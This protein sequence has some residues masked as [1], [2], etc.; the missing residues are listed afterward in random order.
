MKISAEWAKCMQTTPA[1]TET[2]INPEAY[3]LYCNDITGGDL[4][5]N[6]GYTEYS[7][8][9]SG[10]IIYGDKIILNEVNKDKKN[11]SLINRLDDIDYIADIADIPVYKFWTPG[12][13]SIGSFV[14]LDTET[15]AIPDGDRV[16]IPTLVLATA[17][18][19]T[20]SYI[21]APDQVPAFLTIHKDAT[22]ILHNAP[23]DR[24]V[25]LQACNTDLCDWLDKGLLRDTG[26]LY[27][28]LILAEEGLVP[29]RWSLDLLAEK[30]L[31]ID[32]PK[33][34]SIRL[35]F[36]QYLKPDGAVDIAGISEE[37]LDYAVKD[38]AVTFMLYTALLTRIDSVCDLHGVQPSLLLGHNIHL[39][40]AIALDVV[41]RNGMC[42][43]SVQVEMLKSNFKVEAEK[44]L[45]EL[46]GKFGFA[47]GTGSAAKYQSIMSDIE[48]SSGITF[49]RT[50]TGKIS[51]AEDDLEAYRE[52]EFINLFLAY[53]GIEKIVST[54]I[55]KL[56]GRQS[57]HPKF[58][59]LV[60]TGR[61]SCASPNIQQLPREGG[62]RDAFISSD[63]HC[64]LTAD[65]SAIELCGLAQI[66]YEKYGSSNMR[67]LINAGKDLH[68]ELAAK[69]TGKNPADITKE[70]RSKAKAAG[71]GFPGGLG[72]YSF[73]EYAR[74]TYGVIFTDE[75]ARNVKELW[76]ETYPEMRMY[77]TE[78]ADVAGY[79]GLN[80]NPLR[81]DEEIMLRVFIKI[82]SGN[83]VSN[84]GNPYP[85]RL[86]NW[87]WSQ[88]AQYDFP[89]KVKF[90]ADIA[91]KH[92]SEELS[93][94]VQAVAS[95][96][97]KTGMI[98]SFCTYCQSKNAPFQGLVAAGA[99]L[100]LY[101]LVREGFR[102]VNFIH[103]EFII[104]VPIEADHLAVARQI[105]KIMIEEM[106]RMI[107]DV[108]I[109]VEYA[110]MARWQK[111]AEAVFDD[112]VN[113]QKL[114]LFQAQT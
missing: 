108:K 28:L 70:E 45:S 53:K 7:Q 71:F 47:P 65:Y 40:A 36:G 75:E 96:I 107:P 50:E 110:L 3:P 104:E 93:R 39:K 24:A 62:I 20:D 30:I 10:D 4:S 111:G 52:H 67:D 26:L 8:Y 90:Q 89:H 19:G 83:P 56:D 17:S 21:I 84:L 33:D 92:G 41:S 13:G 12:V 98:K 5:L 25:I 29:E 97:W 114:L 100:A 74:L 42:I 49:T 58:N 23:F 73:I 80:E 95:V 91:A 94:A 66:C 69:I 61:V 102:V 1:K 6:S 86:V 79:Y 38:A 101:R 77:M 18:N 87:V 34:D 51:S 16:T 76:F 48:K 85:E 78:R 35:T 99:K 106:A 68:R 82:I 63:G 31:D 59:T 2:I 32:L 11:I 15:E 43:D 37:H 22:M 113:P 46:S 103:D 81:W 9:T 72:I 55:S 27:R 54:F 112:P 44:L 88:I 109:G 64:L 105:E 57:V 60:S 14:A